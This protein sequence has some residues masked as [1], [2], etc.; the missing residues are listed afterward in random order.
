MK[1]LLTIVLSLQVGP[2]G[3]HFGIV[4]CLFVEVIQNWQL[5]KSPSRA[6]F[7]LFMIVIILFI[8]GTLP[9][10]DNFAHIFGF[11]S[12]L[13]STEYII[14]YCLEF[15]FKKSLNKSEWSILVRYDK[16]GSSRDPVSIDFFSTI[17]E[18]FFSNDVHNC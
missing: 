12:G 4:A 9:W 3:S 11:I 5:L 6:L 7:K 2:A 10:I 18:S 17:L 13:V 8:F 15:H 14:S 16:S 1:P